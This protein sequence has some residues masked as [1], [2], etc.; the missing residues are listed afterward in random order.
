[1]RFAFTADIHLSKYGQD[2]IEDESNLPER[3]HSIK[4]CLYEIA[5]YCKENGIENVVLGGDILHG[6]SVIYAI[7]QDILLQFLED[8]KD[9]QF[10]IIDGNHDLSGKGEDVVSALRPLATV[11]PHVKWISYK[12]VYKLNDED[13]I[14]VPY[15]YNVTQNVKKYSSRILVSHFGLNE[16]VV[17][18]GMSMV[19]DLALK[20]LVN[21]YQ[22]VLLGHYHKPQEFINDSFK[23]YYS[24]SLIQLD[25]GE[26]GDQKRFLI[27]D[28]D[29]L[30]VI[31]IPIRGYRQHIEIT[32]TN[33]NKKDALKEAQKQKDS[34]NY[35]KLITTEKIDLGKAMDE[36]NVV[37]KSER[38]IT[39]RGISSSMT[40]RDKIIKYLEIQGIPED[41]YQLYMDTALE[42]I[43]EVGE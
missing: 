13:M 36:F 43:N 9:L 27:V 8:H 21:R 11:G 33:E 2:R 7:A 23:L 25:W 12:E 40:Q 5:E 19:S 29:T 37:D 24:G 32:V 22:L 16:A 28:T 4:M 14:F 20:D 42:I 39:S 30:D 15:S 26:K 3:L 41:D 1:M 18:S 34:G 38:D 31:S 10:Y 17:N 6:K 35:V